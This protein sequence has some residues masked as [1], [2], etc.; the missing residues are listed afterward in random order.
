MLVKNDAPSLKAPGVLEK[1]FGGETA[2]GLNSDFL[3]TNLSL[4]KSVS[5]FS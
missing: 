4:G 1:R 2:L 3:L 5:N